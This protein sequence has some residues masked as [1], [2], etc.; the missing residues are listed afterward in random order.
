MTNTSFIFTIIP[1]LLF[2]SV[3]TLGLL[4]FVDPSGI[5]RLLQQI[6]NN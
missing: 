1:A 4:Y 2:G 3:A 6:L 5:T